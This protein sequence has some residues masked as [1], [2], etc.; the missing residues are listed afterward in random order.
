MKRNIANT[1]CSSVYDGEVLI[2][3]EVL[4]RGI[5]GKALVDSGC[6]NTS[7]SNRKRPF[8]IFKISFVSFVRVDKFI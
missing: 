1:V 3:V 2:F 5:K 8:V 6:Q 4:I 7:Y